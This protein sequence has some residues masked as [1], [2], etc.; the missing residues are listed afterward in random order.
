MEPVM[1]TFILAA[2]EFETFLTNAG[3]KC[4]RREAPADSCGYQHIEYAGS[5]FHIHLI[6]EKGFGE[7]RISTGGA[8]DRR[9]QLLL[10]TYLLPGAQQPEMIFENQLQYAKE[11]WAEIVNAFSPNRR[12]QTLVDLNAAAENRAT[13]IFARWPA[14]VIELETFLK[15]QALVCTWRKKPNFVGDWKGIR[16]AGNQIAIEIS[17][18]DGWKIKFADVVRDPDR[19]YGFSTIH[20]LIQWPHDQRLAFVDVFKFIKINWSN[21]VNLFSEEKLSE[22]RERISKI[23]LHEPS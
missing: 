11:H 23:E 18:R 14:V 10:F 21:I 13:K 1:S 4:I 15:Q 16:Y 19:W 9:Y 12:V 5:E 22:T 7:I 2:S 3:L 8:N 20:R 17:L 6:R